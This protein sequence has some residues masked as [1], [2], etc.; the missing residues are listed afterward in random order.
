MK[1]REETK[2]PLD[3]S[4]LVWAV[5]EIN[6]MVRELENRIETIQHDS[7]YGY[8]FLLEP[9]KSQ[10]LS[11]TILHVGGHLERMREI[12]TSEVEVR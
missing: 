12:I 9:E 1:D 4:T 8:D 10:E 5:Q 7:S 3:A 2:K 6:G 11:K